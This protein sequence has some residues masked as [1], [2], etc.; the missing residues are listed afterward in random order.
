MNNINF[1]MDFLICH[2]LYTSIFTG[3]TF[4]SWCPVFFFLNNEINHNE[5]RSR[6]MTKEIVCLPTG[7]ESVSIFA[8][9]RTTHMY[10]Q[11]EITFIVI[12]KKKL[13]GKSLFQKSFPAALF[14][15]LIRKHWKWEEGWRRRE[16][17]AIKR[18][19][20]KLRKKYRKE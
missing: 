3:S 12:M 1:F 10:R 4:F 13:I 11:K 7:I 18:K 8:S 16:N 9:A 6:S 2:Y 15:D 19:G 14:S 17:E 20:K 5:L